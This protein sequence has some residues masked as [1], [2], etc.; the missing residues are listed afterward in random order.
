MQPPFFPQKVPAMTK[1]KTAKKKT[2]VTIWDGLDFKQMTKA[3]A[4]KLVKAKKA[5]H[6][7]GM[8]DG[9]QYKQFSEFEGNKKPYKN[10]MMS[11]NPEK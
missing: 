7:N 8:L 11:T 6:V 1:K 3:E 9:T 10:K 5:Q 2:L 4:N